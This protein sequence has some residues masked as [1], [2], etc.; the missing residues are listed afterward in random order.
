MVE[1]EHDSSIDHEIPQ[2]PKQEQL[3]EQEE[4]LQQWQKDERELKRLVVELNPEADRL[5]REQLE[6]PIKIP[7]LEPEEIEPAEEAQLPAQKEPPTPLP[8]KEKPGLNLRERGLLWQLKRRKVEQP[9]EALE[10]VRAFEAH[11]K[12]GEFQH[13][14]VS[15]DNYSDFSQRWE[16]KGYRVSAAYSQEKTPSGKIRVDVNRDRPSRM[17]AWNMSW[18]VRMCKTVPNPAE[19]LISLE[20]LGFISSH[21]YKH[22]VET[23]EFM[24]AFASEKTRDLVNVL[25]ES[26]VRIADEVGLSPELRIVHSAFLEIRCSG[27]NLQNLQL[28]PEQRETLKH[29]AQAVETIPEQ[30]IETF[31][32]LSDHP[33]TISY[34]TELKAIN[35]A[36][37][38]WEKQGI[39]RS[40]QLCGELKIAGVLARLFH[41]GVKFQ[42]D[43]FKERVIDW[44]QYKNEYS[45]IHAFETIMALK[46]FLRG[47]SLQELKEADV[48]DRLYCAE[49]LE[50]ATRYSAVLGRIPSG[51][52]MRAFEGSQ[53]DKESR[54]IPEKHPNFLALLTLGR[55][56]P[57]L[58]FTEDNFSGLVENPYW[59]RALQSAECRKL[60]DSMFA[61]RDKTSPEDKGKKMSFDVLIKAYSDLGERADISADLAQ[62]VED[63]NET[64]H[65]KFH[66]KDL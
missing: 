15:K 39:I 11:F 27:V 60:V 2:E 23:E 59:F 6:E 30:G 8:R 64:F 17:D 5:I 41:E 19:Y 40:A 63:L 3:G 47:K 54:K 48:Y 14:T 42:K 62:V 57:S 58:Y 55:N 37:F 66:P 25:A 36:V 31:L 12:V 10:A 32:G 45:N 51:A 1:N 44:L 20:T 9:K 28:T 34:L 22:T 4:E 7:S 29:L 49:D 56:Y 21:L 38:Q 50:R 61:L 26:G 16:K 13:F 65:Y 33:E 24:D 46:N 43:F 35:P 18:F 52:E 53:Y